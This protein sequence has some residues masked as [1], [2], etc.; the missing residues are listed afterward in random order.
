MSRLKKFKV[1]RFT[2]NKN[3]H[4]ENDL[5]KETKDY[6]QEYINYKEKESLKNIMD[7]NAI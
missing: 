3:F 2:D 5:N 6:K 1:K 4:K 7:F